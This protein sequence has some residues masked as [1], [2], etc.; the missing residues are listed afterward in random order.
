MPLMRISAWHKQHCL[1]L[2]TVQSA[3]D[4]APCRSWTFS[5]M[6]RAIVTKCGNFTWL[7]LGQDNNKTRICIGSQDECA[8]CNSS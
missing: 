1:K 7:L 2:V 3:T 8:V 6:S 5:L 4:V